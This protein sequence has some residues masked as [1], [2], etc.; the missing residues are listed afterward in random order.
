MSQLEFEFHRLDDRW[1]KEIQ[2]VGTQIA[3]L[4]VG[5]IENHGLEEVEIV[6]GIDLLPNEVL[7]SIEA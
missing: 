2:A 4:K 1:M 5:V 7:N 3:T 6:K